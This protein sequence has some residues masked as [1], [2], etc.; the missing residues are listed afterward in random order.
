MDVE[1]EF[2]KLAALIGEPARA[3]MLW[4]LTDGR[5]YT[6]GELA[7][8]SNLSPQAAS[9]H[10]SKLVDADLLIVEKQGKHRYYR[11]SKAEVA[12]AIEGM[13]TLLAGEHRRPEMRGPLNGDLRYCRTCYDHLAGKF[14]VSF[15]QSMV[16][17][18]LLG[19]EGEDFF[20][21][22]SGEEWLDHIGINLSILKA[23]RRSFARCCLDWTERKHHIGGALGAAILKQAVNRHWVRIKPNS[24]IAVVTA[25][26]ESAFQQLGISNLTI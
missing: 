7:S 3:I 25:A 26:G 4:C 10:L 15:S 11:F 13:A 22:N 5:A 9:N 18:N 8:V 12:Y 17:N 23:S 16:K 14:A 20:V 21:T 19:I 24:R 2:S 6:A 1:I